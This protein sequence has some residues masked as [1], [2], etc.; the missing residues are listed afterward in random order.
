VIIEIFLELS[1]ANIRDSSRQQ[2]IEFLVESG[3]TRSWVSKEIAAT[4][5]VE[6]AGTVALELA[7][8]TIVHRPYGFCLFAY[9]GETVAGNVVIGPSGCEPL[10]GT[11]VLQ[12]FRIVVDLERHEVSRRRAM[13]AKR[14]A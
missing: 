5:G 14:G 10:V 8:G 4:V 9:D 11:H 13:R 1:I 7:D 6:P 12:D 2:E 3:A